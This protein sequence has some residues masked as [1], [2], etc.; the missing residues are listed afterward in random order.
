MSQ[1]SPIV[2]VVFALALTIALTFV[3]RLDMNA[4]GLDLT[5]DWEVNGHDVENTRSQPLE[6]S[7]SRWNVD[8]L[9]PRWTLTTAG[10]VSA[11]PAVS[12]EDAGRRGHRRSRLFLYYP[13][14]G[15][16]LWKVEAETGD[17][18]WSRRI[19]EYNGITGSIS[20]T[21]P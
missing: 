6:F 14:W 13:D 4:D 12:R 15:G 9:S 10:D 8:R 7:I 1:R 17:I 20:R 18:V 5:A 11:T 16:M 3:A 2:H 21:S 19:S